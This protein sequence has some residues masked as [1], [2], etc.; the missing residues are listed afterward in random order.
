MEE[1]EENSQN[2]GIEKV[3]LD[4]KLELEELEEGEKKEEEEEEKEEK[5]EEEE[6][7]EEE[8][9]EEEKEDGRMPLELRISRQKVSGEKAKSFER[10]ATI[11][12]P[13]TLPSPQHSYDIW[14]RGERHDGDVNHAYA[15]EQA[16]SP[17]TVHELDGFSLSTEIE[18][19]LAVS[20][21]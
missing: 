21:P 4:V 3:E 13:A 9:V 19:R 6:E 14:M 1:E 20:L 10:A 16:G 11:L 5:E 8:E 12:S 15:R 17:A 2:E 18:R 7:E